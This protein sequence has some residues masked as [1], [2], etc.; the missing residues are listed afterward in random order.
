MSELMDQLLSLN[1]TTVYKRQIEPLAGMVAE[2]RRRCPYDQIFERPFLEEMFPDG[3][4]SVI[5]RLLF[6]LQKQNDIEKRSR[7][8]YIRVKAKAPVCVKVR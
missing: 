2:F 1:K 5:A 3:S 6:I 8:S 7:T 4:R